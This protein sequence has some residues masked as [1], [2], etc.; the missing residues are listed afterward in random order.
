VTNI[1]RALSLLLLLSSALALAQTYPS[2]PVRW[3]VA[4]GPGGGDD[5]TARQV[6]AELSKILGQP[7]VVEN[8]P[9]AGGMIGQ[10]FVAKSAPDGYTLLLAG[11]SMAG[12][13]YVNANM[14]YD[15]LRD[16]TPISL[17]EQSPFALIANPA[18][19][20]KSVSEFI[21]H[22]RAHPGK[23]TYA[24]LGAGQIPYWGVVLFNSMA[25]IQALE[26][27]YKGPA[28]AQLDII[29]GRVDYF[30]APVVTALAA[31]EKARVLGVTT[32]VRSE[33]LPDVPTIDEA[34]LARYDMPAWRSLMGP[35]GMNPEHVRILN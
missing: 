12:A 9:G 10:A 3:I 19:P 30:V 7:F 33:M 34:G 14:G 29:A 31:K 8:R 16:F 6:A 15:L 1:R 2:K 23:L 13:H 20:A 24:T 32:Q 4:V 35:A 22:A 27:Q 21:A 26:V 25:K 18:L 17:L 11:G 28:D 5:F